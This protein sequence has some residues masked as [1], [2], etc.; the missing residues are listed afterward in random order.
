M[1]GDDIAS[2]FETLMNGG[3]ITENITNALTYDEAYTSVGNLW[4][5]LLMTGYVTAV[6][7]EEADGSEEGIRGMELRIPNREVSRIFQKTVVDHFKQT[8]DQ[9]RISA[10]M[11][12]LWNGEER[13]ASEILSDLLFETISYMDY[14]ED[15]YHAFLAGIFT[16]R[17][18]VPQ[19]NKEQGL[20]RPDVDLRDRRNRRMMIIECKKSDS[21]NR[22]EY[23]CDQAIQ[24]IT[25]REYARKTDGFNTVRCYGISFFEKSAMVKL[26]E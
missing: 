7:Q 18:Y 25:D 9:E 11:N 10:L 1:Q 3:T 24:Q 8:V 21:K 2:Q 12:A 6:R 16:G 14:H 19:S 15:Y 13:S 17:G 20:G 23:W 4:S 5:I 26:M 22:M